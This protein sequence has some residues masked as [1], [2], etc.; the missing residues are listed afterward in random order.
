MPTTQ[1]IVLCTCQRYCQAPPEGKA[2]PLQTWQR[3]APQRAMEEKMTA[4]EA[5][6]MEGRI[7]T[8]RKQPQK[9]FQVLVVSIIMSVKSHRS[10]HQMQDT[11]FGPPSPKI[12]EDATERHETNDLE[13]Q[14]SLGNPEFHSTQTAGPFEAQALDENELGDQETV[15]EPDLFNLDCDEQTHTRQPQ[16]WITLAELRQCQDTIEQI[17]EYVFEHEQTQWTENEY[18]A[19]RNP[20]EETWTLDDPDFQ[21]SLEIYLALSSRASEAT[22]E[23]I[24]RSIERR[25][26]SGNILSFDQVR[27]RLQ[28]I[29]GIIP[30]YFDMCINS[31]LAYTGTH[32]RFRKC[33]YCREARFSDKGLP[34]RQF[35]TLPLGPQLQALW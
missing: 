13:P 21:L 3:H 22:Y 33:P 30:L 14:I 12:S 29:T 34:R 7:Q 28:S 19:F 11:N 27:S 15:A 24:R 35:V 8:A 23:T 25:Y 10:V 1:K 26:P 2:V 4:E 16:P 6:V 5:N 31:C 9:H 32:D 17:Q 18:E 20:P